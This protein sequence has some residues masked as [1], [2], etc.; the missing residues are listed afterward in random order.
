[1]VPGLGET[2]D[3]DAD[4]PVPCKAK[5][6]LPTSSGREIH[7]SH[8]TGAKIASS[9]LGNLRKKHGF[10]NTLKNDS[11]EE[12]KQSQLQSL[13]KSRSVDGIQEFWKNG[14]KKKRDIETNLYR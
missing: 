5:S 12:E 7:S 10:D 9:I 3:R 13:V 6:D 2:N 11:L 4:V 14:D 1:M 8:M